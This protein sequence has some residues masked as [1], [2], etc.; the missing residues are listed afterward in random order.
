MFDS[1][2]QAWPT[3]PAVAR[4]LQRELASLVSLRDGPQ[5]RE[6]RIVAGV[7]NAY[8]KTAGE[9]WA[10]AAAVALAFPSL[11]P[12]TTAIAWRAVTFPYVP[13]LLAFREGPAVVAAIATLDVAPDLFLFDGQGYAHPRRLGLASHL[14]VLLGRPSIGCAKSRLIGA[15][16]EPEQIFGAWTPLIDRGETVGAVVRTRPGHKP[17]FVSP[18][19]QI[20]VARAVTMTLGCCR[21]GRFLPEPTRLAHETVS[22]ERD[23]RAHAPA[24]IAAAS[25]RERESS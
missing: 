4:E 23:E 16:E 19:H 1:D 11:T 6:V 5:L 10:C 24:F 2:S 15:Y 20:S 18:G 8:V 13:G 14:G 22:K 25:A 12:L 3:A 9:T 21:D 7:D 17:L